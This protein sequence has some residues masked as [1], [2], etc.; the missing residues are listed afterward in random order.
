[1]AK[2]IKI[3]GCDNLERFGDVVFVHGLG[4]D[5]LETWHANPD[6]IK[7]LQKQ[8]DR[9]G[10]RLDAGQLDFW[11]V[12]LG[13]DRPDLGIWSLDYEVAPT[14]WRGDTNPLYDQANLVLEVFAN[15]EIGRHPVVFVTHSMGGL[16]I[17]QTLRNAKG[18]KSENPFGKS[19]KASFSH[20]ATM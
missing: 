17:K 7:Q 19:R 4:G 14:A 18:A 15:R 20:I 6:E 8:C 12:W 16:L 3:G 11:P 1:M 9:D 10:T 2:L 5:G 13:K